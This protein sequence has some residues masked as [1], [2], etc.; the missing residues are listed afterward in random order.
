M[1]RVGLKTMGKLFKKKLT[2][3]VKVSGTVDRV[4]GRSHTGRSIPAGEDYSLAQEWGSLGSMNELLSHTAAARFRAEL[5]F[6]PTVGGSNLLCVRGRVDGSTIT[7]W[8][9]MGPEDPPKRGG[10]YNAPGVIALYLCDSKDGV[11]REL[12]P[13][14]GQRVFLQDYRIPLDE[15]R[16]ADC[17]SGNLK[18]F[19]KAV[20]DRAESCPVEGRVESSDY[21]FS[22][23]VGQLVRE[24]DFEGM[25]V[26]GVR[27][28]R[29][30]Q[31]QN[32]VVF[33]KHRRW[34]L[35]SCQDAGFR[36]EIAGDAAV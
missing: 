6:T 4:I 5:A 14:S 13:I 36:C 2:G 18:D 12:K 30:F 15:L 28:D 25:R 29:E 23:A 1:L 17:S 20:F 22:R 3:N 8:Q 26:P 21:M 35:W 19:M 32:V 9:N 10:R 7:S 33:D 16:L 31:Y 27:G 34:E 24:A 11:L